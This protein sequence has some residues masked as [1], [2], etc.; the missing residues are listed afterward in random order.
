MVKIILFFLFSSIIQSTISSTVTLTKVKEI[1]TQNKCMNCHGNGSASGDFSKFNSHSEWADSKYITP[2]NPDSSL[3]I[4]RLKNSGNNSSV[5]NMPPGGN[6][7]LSQADYDTLRRWI[8]SMDDDPNPFDDDQF[9]TEKEANIGVD[10]NSLEAQKRVFKNCFEQMT[11]LPFDPNFSLAVEVFSGNKRGSVACIELLKNAQLAESNNT[12]LSNKAYS[13]NIIDTFFEFHASWFS[14]R[15]FNSAI[16]NGSTHQEFLHD[17]DQPA[18]Y[19]SRILHHPNLR[20]DDLFRSNLSLKA[21]REAV[22]GSRDKLLAADVS[23]FGTNHQR[24]TRGNLVGIETYDESIAPKNFGPLRQRKDINDAANIHSHLGGGVL[25]SQSYLMLNSGNHGLHFS[26]GG[27]RTKR[28]LGQN[29]YKQFFCRDIPVIRT[30]D[31][32]DF[33]HPEGESPLAYRNGISCMQCHA[34]IDPLAYSA[35]NIF[36]TR[37]EGQS[38]NN[39]NRENL[40]MFFAYKYKGNHNIDKPIQDGRDW[41]DN[42]PSFYEH[43]PWGKLYYRTFDGKLINQ[44]VRGLSQL[45]QAISNQEDPYVCAA[46]RYF[47]FFTG[48]SVNIDDIDH[49]LSDIRISEKERYYRNFVIKMGKELKEHQKLEKLFE[50]IFSSKAYLVPGLGVE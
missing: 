48:I 35:R 1:L 50:R 9:D 43:A 49:S 18:L 12:L 19:L 36:I 10:P 41:P 4:T 13:K 15:S 38:P 25:G 28:N 20:F 44:D 34:S 47:K 2:G 45:G 23:Y 37:S 21:V 26:N 8:N 3:L 32:L 31:A 7:P 30:N 39:R 33:V 27:L 40:R 5:N 29:F 17:L 22:D 42:D 6:A 46:S 24:I 16:S 14:E 11:R